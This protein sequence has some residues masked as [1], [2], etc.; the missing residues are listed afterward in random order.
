MTV[1]VC[2]LASDTKLSAEL[3]LYCTFTAATRPGGGAPEA[4]LL[5]ASTENVLDDA[6]RAALSTWA[7][8]QSPDFPIG[9]PF[10]QSVQSLT[11]VSETVAATAVLP[12]ALVKVFMNAALPVVAPEAQIHEA[13][14]RPLSDRASRFP[15]P[16]CLAWGGCNRA[17][18]TSRTERYHLHK[19]GM[20]KQ[21]S[22]YA[23]PEG[24]MEPTGE[25]QRKERPGILLSL[26]ICVFTRR[27]GRSIKMYRC[28]HALTVTLNR[29]AFRLKT[30]RAPR[31]VAVH[32]LR[33]R[34]QG[35]ALNAR[36][37]DACAW[38]TARGREE[39]QM[40]TSEIIKL[41]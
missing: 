41:R 29:I 24:T 38:E 4:P 33:P 10:T 37:C 20:W 39:N 31:S 32:A 15:T 35:L 21:R 22:C 12:V 5:T 40:E 6:F 17:C 18:T 7:F 19:K 16:S 9:S 26:Y 13:E 14:D 1:K 30:G 8:V 11:A 3:S 25:S 36:S 23:A 34:A 27:A 2:Q 28:A